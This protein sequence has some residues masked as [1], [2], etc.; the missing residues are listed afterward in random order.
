MDMQAAADQQCCGL[1]DYL[2]IREV[3][4]LP[5]ILFFKQ[6]SPHGVHPQYVCLK[7]AE[8]LAEGQAIVATKIRGLDIAPGFSTKFQVAW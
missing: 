5:S 7:V 3:G 2:V 4:N 8:L 6:P 1:V